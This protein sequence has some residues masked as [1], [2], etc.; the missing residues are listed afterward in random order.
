MSI[1]CFLFTIVLLN[2]VNHSTLTSGHFFNTEIFS[3][4]FLFITPFMN[5][6]FDKCHF[7]SWVS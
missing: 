6:D 3:I 1:N 2:V 7:L 5:T 4:F